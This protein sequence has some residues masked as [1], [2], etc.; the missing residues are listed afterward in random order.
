MSIYDWTERPLRI[1]ATCANHY[2]HHAIHIAMSKVKIFKFIVDIH[3]TPSS[4]PNF[5]SLQRLKSEEVVKVW[6]HQRG[7]WLESHHPYSFGY[8]RHMYI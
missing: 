3:Q 4:F 2:T 5:P 1:A 8:V 7:L 6:W